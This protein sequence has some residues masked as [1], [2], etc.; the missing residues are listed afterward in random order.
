MLGRLGN[1][2][3]YATH[4]L[5]AAARACLFRDVSSAAL[6]VPIAPSARQTGEGVLLSQD[7]RAQM[8]KW[9]RMSQKRRTASSPPSPSR[10]QAICDDRERASIDN[11][12]H[13]ACAWLARRHRR[14]ELRPGAMKATSRT[15][16]YIDYQRT[17]D[18]IKWRMFKIR[19]VIDDKLRNVC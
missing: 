4:S 7:L 10:K 13:L 1:G 11:S 9:P 6:S 18:N 8:G 12:C 2:Q 3:A 16:Y 19:K 15:W 14:L 17:I 5:Q